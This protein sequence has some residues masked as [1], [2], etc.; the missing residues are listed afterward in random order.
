MV[1]LLGNK[2]E[3]FDILFKMYSVI[4]YMEGIINCVFIL[5]KLNLTPEK[6]EE[7]KKHYAQKL[8]QLAEDLENA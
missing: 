1:K 2:P 3:P 8:R 6:I 4:R 5:N 7:G